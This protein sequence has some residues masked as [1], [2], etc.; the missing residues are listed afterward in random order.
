MIEGL[1]NLATISLNGSSLY[2]LIASSAE[3]IA[4]APGDA[5]LL[6]TLTVA[7]GTITLPTGTLLVDGDFTNLGGVFQHNNGTVLMTG[8]AA[9]T[10]TTGGGS[11]LNNFYNLT[12]DGAGS[13]LFTEGYATTTNNFRVEGG[14]VTLPAANLTVGGDFEV[15]GTG[16][17]ND[18]DAKVTLLLQDEDNL[19]LNN[20]TLNDVDFIAPGGATLAWYD[21]NWQYRIPVTI[22]SSQVDNN[23]TDFPVYID[24]NTLGSEFSLT[25]I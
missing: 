7:T 4:F 23:I 1:S 8:T 3:S 12:F 18:N 16:A 19:T 13:A 9:H 2:N 22:D 25:Q 24:L 17:V 20:S 15:S 11:F 6:G 14:T 21:T 5:S 10:V